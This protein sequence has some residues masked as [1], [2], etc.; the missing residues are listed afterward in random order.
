MHTLSVNLVICS[1]ICFCIFSFS[2]FNG[3]SALY[4][5]FWVI[6][7]FPNICFCDFTV[8]ILLHGFNILWYT[9]SFNTSFNFFEFLDTQEDL[10]RV[11]IS[12]SWYISSRIFQPYDLSGSLIGHSK[13]K[14]T[15]IVFWGVNFPSFASFFKR[16]KISGSSFTRSSS[17]PKRWIIRCLTCPSTRYPSTR[18]TCVL[19]CLLVVVFIYAIILIIP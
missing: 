16:S 9:S 18:Y 4:M 8:A 2:S 10:I 19:P 1:W 13:S 11:L 12:N 5:S 15:S 6:F 7:Q 14:D 17:K 3:L